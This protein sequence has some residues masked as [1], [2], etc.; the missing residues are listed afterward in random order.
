VLS[1]PVIASGSALPT[2]ADAFAPDSG[3]AAGLLMRFTFEG[4]GI[5]PDAPVSEVVRFRKD[6]QAG[7]DRFRGSVGELT[8]S[9]SGDY[10]SYEAFEQSVRDI[11]TTN[12]RPKLNE[13]RGLRSRALRKSGPDLWKAGACAAAPWLLPFLAT[14]PALVPAGIALGAVAGISLI[15]VSVGAQ[16]AELR[17]AEPFSVAMVAERRFKRK[18]WQRR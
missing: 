6:N 17:A 12:V 2:P 3:A 1:E 14:P 13:L 4:L 5:P 9:L 18:W 16:L 7:L 15:G 8:G 11:Y 10:P